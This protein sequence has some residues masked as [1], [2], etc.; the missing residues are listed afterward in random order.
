MAFAFLGLV[1]A[2]V[3]GAQG[4]LGWGLTEVQGLEQAAATDPA[5]YAWLLEGLWAG[6]VWL[7]S[8]L[9]WLVYVALV[10]GAV[11]YAPV[12]IALAASVLLPPLH[13]RIFSRARTCAGASPVKTSPTGL[14]QSVINDLRRLVRFTF[15]SVMLLLLHVVPVVGSVVYVL[16]QFY[17]SAHTMGWDL[18]AHHFELHDMDRHAQSAWVRRHKALMLS[19]GGGAA[20][21]AMIPLAQLF[22]INTNVAAAGVLSA[23]IEGGA[24]GV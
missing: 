13:G 15:F 14:A 7:L 12:L 22:L 16:A 6:L 4:V 18:L 21:L 2:L 1:S 20:L 24:P 23:R 5:W 19:F 17:L 9:G 10:I 8:A 3:W 11:M